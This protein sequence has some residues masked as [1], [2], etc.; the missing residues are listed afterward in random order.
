M[1]ESILIFDSGVGGLSILSEVRQTLPG[2]HIRYLMDSAMFPYGTRPDALL[3]QRI[4]TVCEAAVSS[5]N[6]DILILACNTASTLALA[7][8]RN[9]LSIPVVGVVP[10]IRVAGERCR[11]R[12]RRAFGLLATPAT[13]TRAYTQNLIDDFAADCEVERYGCSELVELAERHIAGEDTRAG[14][15]ALIGSWLLQHPHMRHVVLGCTH[16]PLL[17]DELQSL[18]PDIDWIDSGA[19]VARQT[20]RVFTSAGGKDNS[21]SCNWTGAWEPS[22]ALHYLRALGP[23]KDAG[24][25]LI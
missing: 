9:A 5:F 11:T 22:A 8:L 7:Q 2:V 12:E 14:I 3:A 18:W 16:F 1:S 13:V 6:P 23:L 21:L 25:L 24:R 20:A 17:K 4:V 10:A 19:A 15:H